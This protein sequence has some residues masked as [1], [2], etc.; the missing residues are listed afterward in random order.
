M[1]D[2]SLV[3]IDYEGNFAVITLNN[4][5]KF[6]SLTQGLFSRL[7][8]LL[9]EADANKD[10]YVTLL[11]GEGPFFSA[12]ADLKDSPPSMDEILSRPYWLPKLVNNNLDVAR[13]FYSHSK[14]LVTA[15]NGPVIGLSAALISHSDFIY[16]VPDAYLLTP[17][18][19]LGLVA[20][21]GASVAFVHRMGPGKANEALILGRKIPVN[22]LVQVGFVNHVFKDKNNFRTQVLE[23]LRQTFS[24]HL[25]GSS[26]L[27]TKALMRRRVVREQDEMAPLETFQGLERFCEGIPQEEMAKAASKVSLVFFPLG[28]NT[29]QT[30]LLCRPR[31]AAR[32]RRGQNLPRAQSDAESIAQDPTSH[33]KPVYRPFTDHFG[34]HS[35][36]QESD[37]ATP[38]VQAALSP[39][40]GDTQGV[41]LV[42][43]LCE[44]ERPDKSGHFVVAALSSPN[45]D[46]ETHE[47]LT[48][49]GCFD[50]P[51]LDI[52]QSL[53]R[54]YFHYV[55]PFLPVI[56][57]SSFLK[58][59]ESPGQNGVCLHLLWSVFLAAANFADATTVQSAGYESRKDMKRAMFLRTKVCSLFVQLKI[60]SEFSQAMYDANYERSKVALIQAVMLMGFWYSD[61]EDRLGPWHWNGI[62]ISLCQTVGLHREPDASLNH[63]QYRSSIDR[64][65]WKNLWWCCFFRETWLSVG[66]GR[67][68]RIN[69]AHSD[70]PKPD[71]K[72]SESLYSE[73]TESQRRR[74]I[75]E[76]PENLFLLW[77]ELLSVTTILSRILSVQHLAKRT[78][79]T[80]SESLGNQRAIGH[81]KESQDWLLSIEKKVT[82]AATNTNNVLSDMI[83]ADMIC[84]SQSLICIALVPT[85]QVHLLH[86][87]SPRK[88]VHRLG[89]H[90]LDLCMMVVQEIKVTYFGAEILHRLFTRA[91][92]IISVRGRVLES[93]TPARTDRSDMVIP[94]G[95]GRHDE[96][97][98]SPSSPMIWDFNATS[99]YGH[100]TGASDEFEDA[101]INAILSQCIFPDFGTI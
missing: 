12:G 83:M 86:S 66:M 42:A 98:A 7:A 70:T 90:Q 81:D 96:E 26:L 41:G 72:A 57:V 46:S 24:S 53:V 10:V 4:P 61:T 67:P 23:Y 22:E 59:F 3:R 101:D 5:S 32:T 35:Q 56:H 37:T 78:L 58:T 33:D 99:N 75:P 31:S 29:S 63:S 88:L 69:L 20:E 77:E 13:A 48:K 44:P 28:I 60:V 19:S 52:Q 64:D 94:E 76:D 18:T 93:S 73:L 85:L 50:L 14:I 1:S 34:H 2:Q 43:D 95:R 30:D 15:L 38:Q 97:T 40:Y 39:V 8:S 21:G 47:Y 54:S 17:F 27:G 100:G 9:R 79:S 71:A 36:G 11:I 62:A 89:C 92:D 25:V 87:V 49:R 84:L 51:A 80:H 16:A 6:N 68:M 74:Y 82:A 45:I 65:L 55:H 91:R